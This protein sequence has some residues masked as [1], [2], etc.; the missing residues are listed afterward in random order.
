MTQTPRE[1]AEDELPPCRHIDCMNYMRCC[2]P[3]ECKAGS[4]SQEH[5]MRGVPSEPTAEGRDYK[6]DYET[7]LALWTECRADLARMKAAMREAFDA[8]S[9]IKRGSGDREA[10][11]DKGLAALATALKGTSP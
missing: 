6:H 7:M 5:D 10:L 2:H 11:A 9:Y 3:G 4:I 1:A 8:L